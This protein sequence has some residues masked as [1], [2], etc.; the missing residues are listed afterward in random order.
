[1]KIKILKI[2]SQVIYPGTTFLDK[3][4]IIKFK[5]QLRQKLGLDENDLL[6]GTVGRVDFQKNPENSLRLQ[7]TTFLK[8]KMLNSYG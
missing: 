1:M 5:K 3:T 2:K 8:I 6:I 7:K 4:K